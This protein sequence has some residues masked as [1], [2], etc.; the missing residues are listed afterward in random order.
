MNS[1]LRRLA[2]R[3]VASLREY[4]ADEQEAVL[5]QAYE[6][7]R[8][9]IARGLGVLD[10]VRVHQQ[11]LET[12]VWPALHG[13]QKLDLRAAETFFLEVLSP[14]EA[15]HR[16]FRETNIKLRQLIATHEKRNVELARINRALGI[17]IR[18]HRRT[19]KALRQSEEHFRDLFQKARRMEDNLRN[20]SNQIL[21]AQ[22]EERKHI[23]RELHDEVGQALTAISVT[24]ASLKTSGGGRA[25]QVSRQLTDAQCLLQETMDTVH[26][27][28]R[29]LRPS[30]LDELGLLP[31]LRS[32]LHGLAQRSGLCVQ[33]RG[34]AL[35]ESLG[36]DEKTVLFRVAQE[37]L[38]NVVKH[39]EA[40]RVMLAIRKIGGGIC[41]EVVDNGK[42][43]RPG[44]EHSAH[45][46]KRM[47][48]LGMQERVR[49]VNGKF[50]VKAEPGKGTTVRV[51][52]PLKPKSALTPAGRDRSGRNGESRPLRSRSRH[53][54]REP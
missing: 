19:E 31:A 5:E 32:Y 10:L 39:A 11:A 43:F 26:R 12:L 27:F 40:S 45:A 54:I 17:E 53:S 1:H 41:M 28:A 46:R 29:E 36:G 6:L 38:T 49:L 33:F 15:A 30:M 16:G 4:L 34:N 8:V 13:H 47:G 37:S 22:E 2:R 35:A 14:F 3:Y 44:P 21:H 18:E 20:L 48:L 9:A 25:R 7:G 50:T 24:L 52:I 42:S 23:S 51:V